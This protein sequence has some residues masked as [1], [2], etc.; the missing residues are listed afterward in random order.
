MKPKKCSV[1][2]IKLQR[3]LWESQVVGVPWLWESLVCPALPRSSD[4]DASSKGG[5]PLQCMVRADVMSAVTEQLTC[6][7][8]LLLQS[9][10]SSLQAAKKVNHNA[11]IKFRCRSSLCCSQY[12]PSRIIQRRRRSRFGA[13]SATRRQPL[14]QQSVAAI[15]QL[16][17]V[18][19]Q[20]RF[21]LWAAHR[22]HAS[23]ACATWRVCSIKE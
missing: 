2:C 17:D 11:I 3:G 23:H 15:L 4:A 20:R 21:H 12:V 8:R 16:I 19:E 10:R 6:E 9:N 7:H 13:A 1:K 5:L 14:P 18:R 22:P